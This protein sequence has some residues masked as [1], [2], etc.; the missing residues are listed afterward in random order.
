MILNQT[1]KFKSCEGQLLLDF[2]NTLFSYIVQTDVNL[3]ICPR[4][5]V[6]GRKSS[7]EINK[8]EKRQ[9]VQKNSVLPDLFV[10]K[11]MSWSD[12]Q[13]SNKLATRTLCHNLFTSS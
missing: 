9:V 10:C 11:I 6:W 13:E 8:E 1:E 12:F 2:W 4:I 3:G 7:Y 5:H